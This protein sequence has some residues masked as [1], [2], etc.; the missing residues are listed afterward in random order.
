MQ[1]ATFCPH[2]FNGST[3][4]FKLKTPLLL[5]EFLSG[6]KSRCPALNNDIYVQ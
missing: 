4:D 3:D 5:Q 2:L 6:D 1:K